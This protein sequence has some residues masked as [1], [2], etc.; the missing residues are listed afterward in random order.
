MGGLVGSGLIAGTAL[1]W[2]QP[3]LPIG[4]GIAIGI[5]G[6]MLR[7]RAWLYVGTITFL[8]TNVY[9][10][11]VLVLEYPV[12]KWAI[13]LLAGVLFIALAANFEKRKEQME[14]VFRHWINLLDQWE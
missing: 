4:I 13:G 5:V 14:R 1:V 12:T 6:L 2:C 3:W 8:L 7:V 11:L 9:Q 10:L